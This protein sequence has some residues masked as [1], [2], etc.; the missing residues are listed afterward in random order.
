MLR[1]AAAAEDL[2][3]ARFSAD[4]TVPIGHRLMGVLPVK[5]REI[6]DPLSARGLVL[7]GAG[8]PIVI[9]VVDWCEIRND[10][11]ARWREGLA[12]AAGTRPGRVLVAA[13][14]Q[15]D[16]P[17]ADLGAERLLAEVGLAGELCDSAFHKDAVRRAAAALRASLPQAAPLTHLGLGKALVERLASNR[18]VVRA[19]GTIT[20]DRGSASGGDPE[21]AAAPE[22][23]IDPWVRALSFWDGDRPLAAVHVYAVHPMS[24]YGRGGVSADFVGEAR[25]RLEAETPGVLH[26]YA[27]GASG[28]VTAGKH[29]DGAPASRPL[30]AARLHAAMAAAWRGTKRLPLRG[31]DFRVER[32]ELPFAEG[33]DLTAA[34]LRRR[35]KDRG[36]RVE[37]RVLAALGLASRLRVERGE[38]IDVPSLDL[39]WAQVVLL[40][41]EAFVGFQLMAQRL[42][43]DS[44]VLT[45]GYGECWP[46]YIPTR[47]AFAEGFGRSWR[48]V[49]RGAAERLRA[50]LWRLLRATPPAL[51]PAA[52][53][54]DLARDPFPATAANPR[55]S[56]GS[57][58]ALDDGSLLYATT[59]F[60]G[61]ADD[62]APARIVARRSP[63][64]GESWGPLATLQENVGRR[65]VMSVSL[66]QVR[67]AVH[68]GL[69]MFYLVKESEDDLRVWMRLSPDGGRSFAAPVL[70]T[71]AAGYHVMN[72]DR[73]A[74]LADGRLIAPVAWTRD[75]RRENHFVSFA[76]L[77]DDGGATWRAGAGRVDLPRRGAMEPEVVELADGGLLMILRTQLGEIHAA[78]SEDR[79]ET[80][81]APAPWGVPSPESPATLRVIPVT[82]SLLL[83]WNP[84]VEAAASHGGPRT[85]LAAAISRD[86]GRTWTRL[87][88]LEARADERYAY[89]SLTFT[90]GR[91]LLGYY[92]EDAETGRISS[93][94]RSLALEGIAGSAR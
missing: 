30:L 16:A 21:L 46:G 18:R 37:D 1:A 9:A 68:A 66:R 82:G 10:A 59:E 92:V 57:I 52:E 65:N 40:P 34:A 51:I 64:G 50:A 54:G 29:N 53:G 8:E 94:F 32:L 63:D 43:P 20:F 84:E 6:V 47:E 74:E 58:A 22:G 25:R 31:A 77:S 70:V 3:L 14:H 24:Y 4:V 39:G 86:E 93:R 79:G 17:V 85:P 12:E 89:T 80:W 45:I 83:V 41:G 91:A 35:L 36:A 67:S 49:G 27:S 73:V 72:N 19:G 26:L 15:H 23:L 7:L 55:Y 44:F 76:Y 62:F 28:D 81:S 88:P 38:P 2:R 75:V 56:E 48:W 42:R 33:E 13:V 78:R 5:A 60:I 11:Y 61:A 90:A 69:A 71:A 87:P